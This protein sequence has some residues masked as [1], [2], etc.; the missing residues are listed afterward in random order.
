MPDMW[1]KD[2]QN[3]KK[4]R[5]VLEHQDYSGGW[6]CMCKDPALSL[7]INILDKIYLSLLAT[8]TVTA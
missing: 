7:T 6:V 5:P 8:I 1:D 4:L 3:W 2:V